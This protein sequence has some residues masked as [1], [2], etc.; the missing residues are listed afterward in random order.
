MLNNDK[1]SFSD[2]FI[3][4]ASN[5]GVLNKKELQELRDISKNPNLKDKY[6]ADN[7][8]QNLDSFT[9]PTNVTYSI[10]D[11]SSVFKNVKFKYTP[12]YNELDRVYGNNNFERVSN[13]SQSDALEETKNDGNRCAASTLL[14]AYIL[15]G[16]DFGVL[17]EKFGIEKEFT[18]KNTHLL[19]DKIY[20]FADKDGA[21]LTSG[22]SYS[23]NPSSGKITKLEATGE[24]IEAAKK[25][26]L[27]ITPLAGD[28]VNTINQ[29]K[30]KV[31]NFLAKNPNATLQIG[32]YLD[33][34]TGTLNSIDKEHPENHSVTILKKDGDFYLVDTG[35]GDNGAG[36]SSTK[37]SQNQVDAFVY[38]SIGNV[39][40]VTL[41]K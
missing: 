20:M 24:I 36:K 3:E 16:G 5:D 10:Q 35:Q 23:Y 27:E 32:I 22:I 31:D 18:F 1:I 33:T 21:G 40:G 39:N 19:Q 14:N 11:S 26:G 12:N 28:T 34:K 29:R 37:L 6:V 7:V 15:Q 13:I 9:K 30:E 17:S 25:L 38:Y 41:K 4:F 8:L 2:R